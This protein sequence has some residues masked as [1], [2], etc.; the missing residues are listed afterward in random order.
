MAARMANPTRAT[1]FALIVAKRSRLSR[2]R[3]RPARGRSPPS[4]AFAALGLLPGAA[5]RVRVAFGRKTP[6]SDVPPSSDRHG[7]RKCRK[8]RSNFRPPFGTFS[9]QREKGRKSALIREFIAHPLR[10]P[11]SWLVGQ[12]AADHHRRARRR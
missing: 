4:L 5:R 10:C 2:W 3:E 6:L 8:C 12:R 7:W 9:R 1:R 11:Q